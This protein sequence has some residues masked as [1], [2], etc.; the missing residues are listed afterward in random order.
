[1][2]GSRVVFSIPVHENVRVIEDQIENLQRFVPGAQVVLHLSQGFYYFLV[3]GKGVRSEALMRASTI[4]RLRAR[5]GVFVN[6]ARLPTEWGNILHT[7]L[8]SFRYAD[9]NLDF[10]T[11][12]L[13][14]SSC[15]LVKPGA[16]ELMGSYDFGI[17][18]RVAELGND[19]KACNETDP[20]YQAIAQEAGATDLYVNQVEGTYY[21]R[22]L[23][24]RMADTIERHWKYTPGHIRVHEEVY[25]PAVAS[26]LPG[27][28]GGSPII[29]KKRAKDPPF[30]MAA[31]QTIRRGEVSDYVNSSFPG[32][33]E[34]TAILHKGSHIFGLRPVPRTMDDPLRAGIRAL[35]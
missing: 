8:S 9:A 34:T 27:T 10:D 32:G 17:G 25:L 20:I 14:S 18:L 29:L 13:L 5:P 3:R 35:P 22:E 6:D 4:P 19:W 24:R 7:H 23:F 1:M 16:E 11:F 30:D 2:E 26:T 33:I 28:N 31:V 12:V 21:R 15:M